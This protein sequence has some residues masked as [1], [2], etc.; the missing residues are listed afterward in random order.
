MKRIDEL[1]ENYERLYQELENDNYE[2]EPEVY[3]L[4][5]EV[6]EELYLAQGKEHQALKTLLKKIKSMKEE[7]DLYDE[8][9]ERDNMFPNR[10][11]DDFDED[12]MNYDSAFGKD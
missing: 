4:E 2:V 12:S 5:Q 10:N 11:D 9:A 3:D 1:N 8:E 6:E 7:F